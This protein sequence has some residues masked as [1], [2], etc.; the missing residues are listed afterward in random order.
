MNKK[1][2]FFILFL[3]ILTLP[4]IAVYADAVTLPGGGWSDNPGGGL[5]DSGQGSTLIQSAM[6]KIKGAAI[7]IGTAMA[8]IGWLVAGI[9]YLSSAGSPEKMTTAK[10]AMI[11]AIIGTALVILATAGTVMSIIGELLTL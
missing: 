2:L 11:A 5:G 6:E 1:I 3:G 10:R 7:I 9:L 4:F 8:I